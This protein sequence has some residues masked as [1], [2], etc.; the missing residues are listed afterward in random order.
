LLSC[1]AAG[2]CTEA[3]QVLGQLLG[4]ARPQPAI[5]LVAPTADQTAQIGATVIVQWADVAFEP[6]TVVMVE[7]LRLNSNGDVVENIVVLANRD[8]MS[9]GAGDVLELDT[10]SLP[11]AFYRF[12]VTIRSPDGFSDE[13]IGATVLTLN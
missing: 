11:A 3:G 13:E 2:G 7:A 9:D 12:R 8:A 4:V 10:T 5:A 1:L 6:G